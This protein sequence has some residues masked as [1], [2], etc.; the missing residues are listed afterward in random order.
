MDYRLIDASPEDEAWLDGLRRRAYEDLFEA[1]W[2]GWD[3]AR[4][5]RQFSESM[6]RGHIS[7]IEIGGR[8][9]GMIQLLA[10]TD[11][12]EVA[13]I[14][15]DPSHQD[16]GVG[17]RVLLDVISD[18]S[19]RGR[20]VRLSVALTNRKAIKLYERLGFSSVE[21]SETHCHMRYPAASRPS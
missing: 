19:A 3:E 8:R 18:A 1:T 21:Q 14:Q 15:I 17:T 12:V 4:H 10:H 9:V 7:I 16:R 20:D 6:R 11:A 5:S 13:E 2:G